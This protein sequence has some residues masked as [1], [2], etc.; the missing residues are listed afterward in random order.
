MN[1]LNSFLNSAK[2]V[3]SPRISTFYNPFWGEGNKIVI[4][5]TVDLPRSPTYVLQ[6]PFNEII[7]FDQ[8]NDLLIT[9]DKTFRIKTYQLNEQDK[10]FAKKDFWNSFKLER[11]KHAL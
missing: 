6:L 9:K 7:D 11:G 3:F 1:K 2:D 8:E 5:D 4:F 10:Y